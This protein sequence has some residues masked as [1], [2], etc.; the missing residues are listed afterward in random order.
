MMRETKAGV[1]LPIMI[2]SILTLTS[3]AASTDGSST[4]EPETSASATSESAESDTSSEAEAVK[5]GE[6]VASQEVTLPDGHGTA[7]VEVEPLRVDGKVQVLTIHVTPQLTDDGADLS[8]YDLVGFVQYRPRLI[9]TENLKEYNALQDDNGDYLV[10]DFA[11][12][13]AANGAT[14]TAWAVFAAP[15]DE[16]DSIDV[17]VADTMSRFVDVPVEQ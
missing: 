2:A 17:L 7:L 14:F 5:N 11:I 13:R 3:C 6:T 10:S 16:I 8:L 4:A 15:E 9:D 12:T 1:V